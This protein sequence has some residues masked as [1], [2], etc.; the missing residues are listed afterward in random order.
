MNQLPICEPAYAPAYELACL[1]PTHPTI[2]IGK[3]HH[4]SKVLEIESMLG[5]TND[6]EAI[7]KALQ[8]SYDTILY[9]K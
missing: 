9:H 4:C 1:H 6:F 7:S 3:N 8:V 2:S 5:E